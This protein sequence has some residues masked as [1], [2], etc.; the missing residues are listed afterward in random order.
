MDPFTVEDETIP[1]QQGMNLFYIQTIVISQ[2]LN[3]QIN[4]S[5]NVTCTYFPSNNLSSL[6]GSKVFRYDVTF[7]YRRILEISKRNSRTIQHNGW[8]Y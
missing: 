4:T 2:K 5:P 1:Y 3:K 7:S 6:C 8:I